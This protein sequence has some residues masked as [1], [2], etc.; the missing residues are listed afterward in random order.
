MEL[1]RALLK[2][3]ARQSL[4]G[5]YWFILLACLAF[6]LVSGGGLRV[7]LNR[8]F[9]P[10]V[11]TNINIPVD[12][13]GDPAITLEGV[14]EIAFYILAIFGGMIAVIMLISIV[15][16]IITTVFLTG[17]AEVSFAKT[18]YESI[19][20]GDSKIENFIFGFSN[21]YLNVVKVMF[22]RA[23]K[24]FLW[25]LL[26]FGAIVILTAL[27]IASLSCEMG[28]LAAVLAIAIIPIA[29]LMSIPAIVARYKY[30]M[31]PY[32]TAENPGITPNDALKLSCE[33]MEGVK[34]EA[35]VLRLSFIGWYILGAL[36]FGIGILFVSPYYHAAE[37]L[38]YQEL[39]ARR[40][41][42]AFNGSPDIETEI[43]E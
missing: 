11:N 13:F 4:K 16:S 28:Y 31:V 39:K 29:L 6:G 20:N 23:L 12:N 10:N 25:S 27:I 30:M 21:Y 2:N 37:T 18:K 5:R 9:T 19:I 43:G 40:F 41:P 8:N 32:I 22:F 26:P 38:L 14:K 17:P 7:N 3:R 34:L 35:F 33:M 15:T 36:C 42:G 1:N 24:I